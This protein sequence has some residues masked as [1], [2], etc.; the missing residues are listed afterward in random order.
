V[1]NLGEIGA[2]RPK[3]TKQGGVGL[4]ERYTSSEVGRIVGLEESQLRYWERLR[5]VRPRARWRERFY[6][7]SDLLAL[8]TIKRLT[9]K[10]I[11]AL[12]LRR[13]IT[14]LE[15]H[16]G[17]RRLALQEL[18]WEANGRQIV[19]IPPGPDSA[20]FEPLSGQWLLPF[21]GPKPAGLIRQMNSLTAEQWFEYAL[22]CDARPETFQE[23]AEA[24]RRAI[25]LE[26]KWVEAHINLGVALYHL[27]ELDN[28]REAFESALALE[29]NSVISHFNLGCVLDELG[30]MDEGIEHLRHVVTL[31]PEHA[32]AHFNLAVAYE[33]RG[34]KLRARE[35]WSLYL[36]CQPQGPWADYARSHMRQRRT[37][38]LTPPIPFRKKG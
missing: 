14:A 23:A 17:E 29:S 10:Q 3:T 5:L 9:A 34:E 12:R 22:S 20:P 38:Q 11:P 32:D 4:G 13:A 2:S 28:A 7:F 19:V 21:Q 15:Q 31:M 1:H 6:E 33:K 26:P 25:E 36:Q 24:Y 18:Q 8:S 27:C 30:Q 37:S 35:H 16:T